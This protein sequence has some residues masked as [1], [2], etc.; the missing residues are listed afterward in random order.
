MTR[1]RAF[2]TLGISE[3]RIP[4]VVAFAK[5][6]G[7]MGV[8]LGS[9]ADRDV[10]TALSPAERA[11]ARSA[12]AEV[13]RVCIATYV[14]I[15]D[16]RSTD[17]EVVARLRAEAV[18]ARDLGFP[19]I[20]VFP[21]GA[22]DGVLVRRL[23]AAAGIARSTGVDVWLETHDSHST[24][25]AVARVLDAVDDAHVGVIWDIAHPWV[26]G[27]PVST[28]VSLLAP[29]LRH[30]QVK[31][32]SGRRSARPVL[33]GSGAL[34]LADVLLQLDARGYGGHLSLE[35]ERRWNP[36]LPPLREAIRAADE[37]IAAHP[38]PARG[39]VTGID[40]AMAALTLDE[41]VSL[42]TGRDFWSTQGIPRIGLRPI[43]LSDGPVG[44]RG[45]TMDERQPSVV[46]PSAG[47]IAAS[48]DPSLAYDA[49]RALA[50]EAV[51]H[52]VDVVL[53][54]TVNLHRSPLGGRTFESFSEDPVLSG[55]IAAGY[56]TG[57]QD[58]GV[59]ACPKHYVL[60][61]SET[62]RMTVS[63]EADERVLHELYLP[64][65][66]D[67]VDAGA[68]AIMSAY[69]AVD[70]VTMT[71]SALLEDPLVTRWGF[72]GVVVSDWSAV[73]SVRA[74]R[75][76]QHLAMPGPDGA[77]GAALRAAIDE[78]EVSEDALDE[79]VRRILRLAERTGALG[80]APRPPLSRRDPGVVAREVLTAGAVLLEND[81]TL[82]LAASEDAPLRVALVGPG[83]TRPRVQGGGSS[84]VFSV[85]TVTPAEAFA[86]EPGVILSVVDGTVATRAEPFD[87][88]ELRAPDGTPGAVSALLLDAEGAVLSDERRSTSRLI[89]LGDLPDRARSLRAEFDVI[90]ARTGRLRIGVDV[91]AAGTLTVD[92]VVVATADGAARVE[93][94]HV[95]LAN[96]LEAV[97]DAVAG[98]PLR[99]L[100]SAQA[101][102]DLPLRILDVRLGRA[103]EADP[104]AARAD[105]VAAAREA[106]VAIVCMG[107]AAGAES[108]GHD[109]SDLRL[110]P[111]QDELVAAVIAANPRTIV[112]IAAGGPV[113]A[114]WRHDAAAVLLTWFGGQEVGS[115]LADL[116]LGRAEPGGRLPTTWPARLEDAPVQD[117]SPRHGV[118]R[119]AE[120]LDI[121]YRA[122]AGA[123]VAPAYPFGYGLGYTAWKLGAARLEQ[124]DGR[125]QVVADLENTGARR[126]RQVLQAYLSH[127]DSE[128]ARPP[129]WLAAFAA[130]E[131]D[132]GVRSTVRLE[133]PAH[134]FAH[135]S[136]DDGGW[137]TEGGA[138]TVSVGFSAT[139]IRW[140][141]RVHPSSLT[142]SP[143]RA[144]A[145]GG[146]A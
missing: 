35:W 119:Y 86:R 62:E 70:G 5:E 42:V 105:A 34:P 128:V 44:V 67:A 135:W 110:P 127:P 12:L 124:S 60:G 11:A 97:L 72:D 36:D 56:V 17:A 140:T 115:V 138:F 41:K 89:W 117:V 16:A 59:I 118:L 142:E 46:F 98:E 93:G 49:G 137:R 91:P 126:G 43:V 29:W 143:R 100:V 96:P 129:I 112:V 31:D 132:P 27:E 131:A 109:R 14:R 95:E 45:P 125:T 22:D 99:I 78:G 122:W 134:A 39:S 50:D 80:G 74:A 51:R 146:E 141:G 113:E 136:P 18:L 133:I 71:E 19:A 85:G 90:P 57:V 88:R 81:G 54:P 102:E 66:R 69:N 116:V 111:E 106:D 3:A 114:P 40:D 20:R 83:A 10:N 130:V 32:V 82:P 103:Y 58:G 61:D 9:A 76:G 73:R 92:G 26:A 53:G 139:D 8:E 120:G 38:E 63:V 37:W 2:S 84:E 47:A 145:A 79:K 55:T 13:E 4:E 65:F 107:T 30:V 52:G 25:L 104:D 87:L 75:A 28:T 24:G 7:W 123:D 121:G 15:A 48:W 64:P 1:R 68:G 33:P 77:W 23:R 108:E 101:P 144:G 21:G 94:A 6:T